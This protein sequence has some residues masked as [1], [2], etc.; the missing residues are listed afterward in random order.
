ML[1]KNGFN[2]LLIVSFCVL[3]FVAFYSCKSE[4]VEV[5]YNDGFDALGDP[6]AI[7]FI[8]STNDSLFATVEVM[9]IKNMNDTSKTAPQKG[10]V[11]IYGQGEL[12]CTDTLGHNGITNS[13]SYS[14]VNRKK[15]CD[16]GIS[17]NLNDG[18]QL[19]A[20]DTISEIVLIDSLNINCCAYQD[21]YHI[22]IGVITFVFN[23]PIDVHNYY[24]VE[25]K[26]FGD[27]QILYTNENV[28]TSEYYYPNHIQLKNNINTTLLFSD[29]SFDGEQKEIRINFNTG[30]GF[31]GEAYVIYEGY[32]EFIFRSVSR[33]YYKYKTS[34][35]NYCY[36]LQSD[37]LYG[38]SEPQNVFC[39]M[40]NGY[41]IFA[42]YREVNY[43]LQNDELKITQ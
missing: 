41:G 27:S 6:V 28:I 3:C 9:R 26:R 39:N 14:D 12:M 35:Y 11:F 4:I 17:I 10:A 43:C 7:A 33:A 37:I 1:S 21:E 23:D 16:Y 29:Q 22:P 5:N 25:V 38:T 31:D 34:H 42:V 18:F 32:F 20:S 24:E 15:Y 30:D 19:N 36:N 2:Y 13:F 40:T 8:K